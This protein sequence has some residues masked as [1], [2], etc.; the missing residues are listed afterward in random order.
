MMSRIRPR[1]IIFLVLWLFVLVFRPMT[2]VPPLNAQEPEIDPVRDL[3]V[4]M[5]PEMKIGQLVLVSFPGTE[6]AD[7]SEIVRLIRDYAIGG[8][9]FSRMNGNFSSS[10]IDAA[11]LISTT[12]YLQ[13]VAI[14]PSNAITSLNILESGIPFTLPDLPLFIAVKP[15]AEGLYPTTYVAGASRLP[16]PLAIGATWN[17]EVAQSVGEALGLELAVLGFNLYLGPDLD[18]LYTPNPGNP[19]DLGTKIFGGDPFWVGELGRAFIKGIHQGSAGSVQV[20]P[21]HLPGLGSADRSLDEEVPTVQKPLEQLKQIELAPFFAAAFSAPSNED[22]ADAFL[23]THIKYR[24]FQ[25]N[26]RQTTR[27]ISLDAQAL[28]SVYTLDEMSVWR[29]GGGVLVA[30]NLGLPSV[31]LSYDPRGIIFNGRRV[32]QDALVAG[33]DL[34]ILDMFAP[35]D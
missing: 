31:H 18:V 17:T 27:P 13:S 8:V 6:V 12:T 34:L 16:K 24:G 28:Q 32:A 30:D 25:G 5:T 15:D 7:N 29:Q 19:A 9:L 4:R 3:I 23:V 11:D 2:E 1:G 22:T 20:A 35:N 21:R 33:N 14:S 10:R 26:I